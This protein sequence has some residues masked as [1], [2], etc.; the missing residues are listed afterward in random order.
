[1]TITMITVVTGAAGALGSEVVRVLLERGHHV[2]ALDRPSKRLDALA[3]PGSCLP[4]ALDL[5]SEPSWTSAVA[6]IESELGPITGGVLCAGGYAGGAPVR[7]T[8][9]D[10]GTYA[11]MVE[12]NLGT[13]ERS[14]HAL[15]PAMASR[16]N[17]SIVVIGSRVVERPWEGVGAAA[18]VASKSA[19]VAYALATAAELTDEFVRINAVL[20][21]VIDTPANRSAMPQADPLRWVAPESLARVIAFLLSDEARDVSGAAI[22]VYARA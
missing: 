12:M 8:P 16:K 15:V 14:I 3:R 9:K 21:S 18:Y 4:I 20:P 19:A 17:G 2:A 11:R 7:T 22:P 6:R 1:M 10:D 5:T 13:V